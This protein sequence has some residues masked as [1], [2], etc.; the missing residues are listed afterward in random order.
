M[1]F[2]LLLIAYCRKPIMLKSA[3]TMA[4]FSRKS[5]SL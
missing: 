5:S 4:A 3:S 2:D 1:T